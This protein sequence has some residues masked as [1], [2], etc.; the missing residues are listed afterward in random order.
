MIYSTKLLKNMPN[1]GEE[2]ETSESSP[3]WVLGSV[4]KRG[5]VLIL[6]IVRPI[7]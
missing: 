4:G 1:T 6:F 3:Y 5:E 7:T 2:N